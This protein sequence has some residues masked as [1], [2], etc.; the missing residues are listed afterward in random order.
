MKFAKMHG[1]GNDYVYLNGFEETVA[2][3]ASL[4]KTLSN[5][6][7]GIGSDGLILI[8][9]ST[10]ADVRMRMFNADG[11]EAE[12]CGNGLRC[13]AKYA[14]DHGLVNDKEITVETG[15]GIR[16]LRLFTNEHDRVDRVRVNMGIPGLTRK[17]IAVTGAP[18]EQA[19]GIALKVLDRTFHITCVSMGNPH[20]VI[21]VDDVEQFSVAKYGQALENHPLFV[22]RTNVEFV[23]LLSAA[24]V[25]QRTWERGA[26]ETLA[27]GT[28]AAAVTV[29]SVLNQ[30]TERRLRIHLRGGDL[31]MEWAED[32]YVYMTG[33]AVQVFEGEY[34]PQ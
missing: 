19:I 20:C 8:L 27:C 5:R 15:A 30:H 7:F 18:D 4:A 34:H 10:A 21:F 2:D 29:A 24:E 16:R 6:N 14:F 12:M 23:E 32:G 9:P 17:E 3:P 11:S 33:P 22:N 25:K 1:A 26:G 31:E 13:V 28:G